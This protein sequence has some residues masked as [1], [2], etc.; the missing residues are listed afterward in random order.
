MVPPSSLGLEIPPPWAWLG[1][2]W[3]PVSAI[4]GRWVGLGSA[5]SRFDPSA[6]C[7]APLPCTRPRTGPCAAVVDS[8]VAGNRSLIFAK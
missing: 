7:T 8:H 2:S 6:R 3:Q 4:G 1:P 5:P